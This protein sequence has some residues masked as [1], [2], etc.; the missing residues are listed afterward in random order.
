MDETKGHENT[1]GNHVPPKT[2]QLESLADAALASLQLPR[3]SKMIPLPHSHPFL[4]SQRN[5]YQMNPPHP[6]F[7][8]SQ[9]H[10]YHRNCLHQERPLLFMMLT[11]QIL[12][13]SLSLPGRRTP[14]KREILEGCHLRCQVCPAKNYGSMKCKLLLRTFPPVWKGSLGRRQ[15]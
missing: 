11:K 5:L 10:P 2:D 12:L 9:R 15:I 13:K 6:I 3:T 7:L 1:P 8:H 14:Q 4:H